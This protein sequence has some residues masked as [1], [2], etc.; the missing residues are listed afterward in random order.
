MFE[1][2]KFTT[3]YTYMNT[4]RYTH[5]YGYGCTYAFVFWN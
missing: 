4:Q 1:Q 5:T 2:I 3:D